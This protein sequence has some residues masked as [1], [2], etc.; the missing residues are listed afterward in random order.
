MKFR[1][2]ITDIACLN[3]F[4]RVV[5]TIS[6]LTKTCVLRLTPDH[7]FFILSGK[8]TNGGVGMWCQLLQANFFQEYQ[9][10]GVSSEVQEICLEVSPEPWSRALKTV[11]SAKSVKLK[12][13]RKHCACLTV[14]A[15]LPTLSSLGRVVTHDVP[16]DVIPRRLW[17]EFQEPSVPD[18]D[19][20][21]YLP[22]LKTMK[23]VVDRM[24][25]LSNFLIWSIR[26]W[27]TSSCSM[28]TCLCSIS[29]LLWPRSSADNVGSGRVRRQLRLLSL[30][31]PEEQMEILHPDSKKTLPAELSC[32]INQPMFHIHAETNDSVSVRLHF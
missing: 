4:T 27:S 30:P 5:T 21:V 11:Q 2:K 17:Q 3:H 10:E 23:S 20:S 26:T 32:C 25:N 16:V 15:E 7:L 8:V 6:K 24:K 9:M 1:G 28:K 29:S 18:F 31:D 12:L 22:P 14:A 13:T 19:V